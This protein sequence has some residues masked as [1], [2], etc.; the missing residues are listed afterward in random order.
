MST[1]NGIKKDW[2]TVTKFMTDSYSIC[3][4]VLDSLSESMGLEGEKPLQHHISSP[5]TSFTALHC[6][7][8][9]NLPPNTS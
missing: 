9:A 8:T 3:T 6:Y 7:P 5:S 1:P 2:S 4:V